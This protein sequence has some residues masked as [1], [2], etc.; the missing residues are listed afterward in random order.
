MATGTAR[1]AGRAEDRAASGGD[2]ARSTPLR[3]LDRTL[4]PLEL[5][6]TGAL[7]VLTLLQPSVGWAGLPSWAL[8]LGFAGYNV[9]VDLARRWGP[10]SRSYRW[11]HL[12][13]VPVAGLA[14]V[15]AGEPGGPLFVLFFLAVVCTAASEPLRFSLLYTAAVALLTAL[16]E[17]TLPGWAGSMGQL[18]S[19]GARLVLLGLLGAS[20]AILT[21]RLATERESTRSERAEAERLGELDRLRDEFISSVSHDLRTPITAARAAL[22]LLESSAAGK[23]AGEERGLL[24][25]ARR[26]TERLGMLIDDLLAVNQLE[27]GTLTIDRN[28]VDLRAVVVRAMGAVHPLLREKGQTL[29]IDIPGPLPVL[30]DAR[31]LEQ[32]VANLYANA[33][34]HTPRGTRIATR[35]RV[36]GGEVWLS[37]A[38]DG[39]GIPPG[40]LDRVFER[41]RRLEPSEAGSGLGLAIARGIVEMHGGRI[42]AEG[43]PARG[44][45]FGIALPCIDTGEE[46]E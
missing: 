32:A 44:A 25:N 1:G 12:L 4:L 29:E 19:L 45:T 30:G 36:E 11:K 43:E 31:R 27:A 42:W 6:T 10:G 41:Y 3:F 35:G 18:T 39:P 9:L 46:G 22:G 16:A 14:Y 5:G 26:N 15:L 23:L 33:H 20:T 40:E 13:D 37:V 21:R 28:P 38:D 17:P 24:D 34:E 2:R 8:V 7:L